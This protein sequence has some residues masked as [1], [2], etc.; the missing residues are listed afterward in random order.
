VFIRQGQPDHSLVFDLRAAIY[1]GIKQAE[2]QI[3]V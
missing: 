1:L 3:F 2:K